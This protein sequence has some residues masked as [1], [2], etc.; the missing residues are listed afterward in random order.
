MNTA[1][2]KTQNDL[3]EETRRAII[4]ALN[5]H[6]ADAIDFALQAKQAHWNVRGPNF[7]PLHGLFDEVAEEFSEF[8]DELAERAVQLGGT[9]RGTLQAATNSSRLQPYPPEL[10]RGADHV[11]ALSVR[12][13]AFGKSARAAIESTNRLGEPI[14]PIFS[15]KFPAPR[16]SYCGSLK[17][18]G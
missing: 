18:M 4:D 16:T 15:R 12:L 6:L 9:A 17:R 13:A 7:V 10:A 1:L 3:P 8:A 5:D 11:Q 14:P 2:F